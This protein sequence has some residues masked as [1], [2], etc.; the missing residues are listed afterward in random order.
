MKKIFFFILIL[1][2]TVATAQT[3]NPII[4]SLGYRCQPAMQLRFHHLRFEAFPFDWLITPFE[5]L[6]ALLKN[7]FTDFLMPENL[8]LRTNFFYQD[9]GGLYTHKDYAHVW[10]KKYNVLIRHDF[11]LDE[12]WPTYIS[13]VQEK[14]ARRIARFYQT[15]FSGNHIYFVRQNISQQETIMLANLLKKKFPA[16]PFTLLAI[17]CTQEIQN[18]W[19]IPGVVTMY[20]PIP[21]PYNRDGN[22]ALWTQLFIRAGILPAGCRPPTIDD[23]KETYQTVHVHDANPTY[24][25]PG[26]AKK[27]PATSV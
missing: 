20:M 26:W 2:A 22:P 7:D 27:V 17:D 9:D 3:N 5:S 14:Y 11:P 13:P 16:L 8:E 15:I 23:I 18:D 25:V 12:T 1:T 4:I 19:H 10:D 24:T 21:Q 6:Y